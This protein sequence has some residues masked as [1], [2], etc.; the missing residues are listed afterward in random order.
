MDEAESIL[1][2]LVAE[3]PEY[4]FAR[5]A[6]LQLFT[7]DGR[8][9]EAEALLQAT[10]IPAETHPA[11]MS[12]WLVAQ[13][14]YYKRAKNFEETRKFIGQAHQI[15]PDNPRVKNLWEEYKDWKP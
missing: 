3:Q 10:V 2:A 14:L 15:S 5:A 13:A 8:T 6:L 9:K 1:S 7:G 12:A 11:A 4:F